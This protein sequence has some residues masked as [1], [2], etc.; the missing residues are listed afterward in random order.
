MCACGDNLKQNV[1]RHKVT[2]GNSERSIPSQVIF[3]SDCQASGK[4]MQ[5]EC[6]GEMT[7]KKSSL[8]H[9]LTR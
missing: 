6:G 7:V 9:L 1:F 8:H 4:C 5:K 2:M 3:S